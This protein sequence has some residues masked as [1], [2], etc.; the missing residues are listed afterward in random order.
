M[1]HERDL[2]KDEV[3]EAYLNA[4]ERHMTAPG[5]V[6]AWLRIAVGYPASFQDLI[7]NKFSPTSIEKSTT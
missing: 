1:Q 4:L 3:W 2:V 6:E 5:F 7:N